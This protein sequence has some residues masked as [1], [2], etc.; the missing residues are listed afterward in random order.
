MDT[1][2]KPTMI[3][4]V[5]TKKPNISP[6]QPVLKDHHPTTIAKSAS[7][8]KTNNNLQESLDELTRLSTRM[9]STGDNEH[10][11]R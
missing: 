9:D 2:K 8:D 3:K 10:H 4:S 5:P 1:N 7:V 6:F 11:N